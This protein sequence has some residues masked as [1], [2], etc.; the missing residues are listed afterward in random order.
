[1]KDSLGKSLILA[2]AMGLCFTPWVNSPTALLLGFILAT[3][4]MLPLGFQPEKWTKK[5]LAYSIVGLGFG[6]NAKEAI[7][8]TGSGIELIVASIA[9]TLILGTI[10][11]RFMKLDKVTGY[12]VTV[13]TAICGGSAIAAVAPAIKAEDKQ[14]GIALATVFTL[15]SLALFVFPAVGHALA[16]DQITFG[17]WAAIAIHD[18]SSVVGASQAYGDVALTTATTLKLSRALWIIPVA[19]MSAYAFKSENKK[20]TIPF[21]IVFYVLAIIASD[22]LPQ[23]DFVFSAVYELSKQTMVLCLFLI[24]SS[25]S[26]ARLKESGVKP[27]ILGT[28]LWAMI[29]VGSLAWLLLL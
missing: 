12:L 14:I 4:R 5:L 17:Q 19:I 24:G 16:L 27:I 1:M 26:I 25:L 23:Y 6:V 10:I 3:L 20:P 8:V 13:G 29:S 11:T 15:N 21:F 22:A 28:A 7:A 2:V 18:T 9:F